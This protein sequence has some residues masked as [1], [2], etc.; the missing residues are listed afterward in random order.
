MT[1]SFKKLINGATS[2][3]EVVDNHLV[4]SLPDAIEPV[5][6]RMALEKIDTASFEV[7]P[8]KDN[9][10]AKLVLKPKKGAA[11]VIANFETKTA[12]VDA[13]MIASKALQRG[14]SQAASQKEQIVVKA[15]TESDSSHE[16]VTISNSNNK[17]KQKWALA[18]LGAFLVLGLYY[19]LTTLIPNTAQS[20]DNA[21]NN[22]LNSTLNPTEATGVP[23]SADDF[24]SGL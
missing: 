23:V 7:K 18:I 12:A 13:L 10:Q 3:A 6:W 9:D 22:S 24:L 4:L 11:E 14:S 21:N 17:E 5:V 19:Y 16:T 20:F 15:S 1:F 8:Q 2:N